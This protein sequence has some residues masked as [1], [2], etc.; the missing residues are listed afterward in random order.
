MRVTKRQLRRI[1]REEKTRLQEIVPPVPAG[2][3]PED[4]PPAEVQ[5]DRALR[6]AVEVA[7]SDAIDMLNDILDDWDNDP[8]MSGRMEYYSRIVGVTKLLE[9]P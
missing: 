5:R 9:G 6:A 3:Y 7:E 8:N 4:E 1:I 2:M